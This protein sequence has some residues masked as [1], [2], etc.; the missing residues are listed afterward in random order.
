MSY[1]K[2]SLPGYGKMVEAFDPPV[3]TR[4]KKVLLDETIQKG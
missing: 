1:A 4:E 2:Q 3:I